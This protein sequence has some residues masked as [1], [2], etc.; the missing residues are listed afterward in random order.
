MCSQVLNGTRLKDP[1]FCNVYVECTNGEAIQNTCPENLYY[2]RQSA[3]CVDPATI[4]CLSSQPCL[5]KNWEF[6]S[7]PYSCNGYYYCTNGQAIYGECTKGS[8]FNPQAISCDTDYE[9]TISMYPESYCNVVPDGVAIKEGNSQPEA[10]EIC[11]DE[12]LYAGSCPQGYVFEPQQGDCSKDPTSAAQPTEPV[13]PKES[14]N[15]NELCPRLANGTLIKD[16]RACNEYFECAENGEVLPRSCGNLYFDRQT[17]ECVNP[18]K[19]ECLS[20]QPCKDKHG[21][22][23]ADPYSCQAYYYCD[24]G[25]A[26][27]AVCPNNVAFNPKKKVCDGKYKCELTMYP[28][29]YCNVVGEGV[30]IKDPQAENAYQICKNG[31]LLNVTCP[32]DFIF[33]AFRGKCVRDP[34]K[35]PETTTGVPEGTTKAP[36]TTVGTTQQS[37]EVPETTSKAPQTTK[38][39]VTTTRKPHSSSQAPETS[40]ST[41]QQ[42]TQEPETSTQGPE[43]TTKGPEITTQMPEITTKAPETSTQ[44]P[45]NTTKGP[46]TTTRTPQDPETTEEPETTDDPEG[47]EDPDV[48]EIPENPDDIFKPN[49]I[50][51]LVPNGTLIKDPRYCNTFVQCLNNSYDYGSCGEDLYF[52]RH[53]GN[54]TEPSATECLSTQPCL[55][56]S[57]VSVADPYSCQHYYKCK[58]NSVLYKKCSGNRNFNPATGKCEKKYDCQIVLYPEDICNIVGNGVSM[59]DPEVANGY[60]VCWDNELTKVLCSEG[61]IYDG[62]QGKCVKV[63]EVPETTAAP[64]TSMEPETSKEPEFTKPTK[65]TLGPETTQEVETTT[66]A[67]PTMAPET[68][69]MP[70]TTPE[71]EDPES[72]ESPN[73]SF[74]PNEWCSLLPNGTLIKDPRYCNTYVQCLDEGYISGTCGGD[75]YFDRHTGQCS[76][77][78]NTPCLSSK[79]CAGKNSGRAPDPYS[80]KGYYSCRYGIGVHRTCQ[81]GRNFNPQTLTCQWSYKCPSGGMVPEDT[82]NIVGEGVPIKDPNTDDG[83]QMCRD[84]KLE[85]VKCPENEIYDAYEGRCVGDSEVPQTTEAPGSSE[86]PGSTTTE[87]N[88]TTKE[89]ENTLEPETTTA[90]QTTASMEPE[91]TSGTDKPGSTLE[92][93]N[94]LEPETTTAHQTTAS[95]E[96]ETTSESDKPG[97]TLEPATTSGPENPGTST[98]EPETTTTEHQTTTEV[99]PTEVPEAPENPP[100]SFD[101]NEWCPML[102]NGTLIKDPRYCNTYVLCLNDSHS[103][104]TCGNLYFDRNT[105]KCSEPSRTDCLSSQPCLG[106]DGILVE[107][108]YSCKNYYSCQNGVGVHKTCFLFKNFNP[109]SQKCEWSYKCP[110]GMVPED[111]CNIVGE[112]VGIKVADMENGYQVCWGNKLETVM[113][114][115]YEIYDGFLGRCVRNGEVTEEPGITETTETTAGPETTKPNS[116]S[117]VPEATTK[118]PEVTESSQPTAGPET[119]LPTSS[120]QVPEVTT[121]EPEV[122]ESTQTTSGPETTTSEVPEVTTKEPEVTEPSQPTSGPETTKPTSTPELPETTTQ[123]PEVTESSQPTSGP[124]TTKPTSTPE[125]PETTTQEPEVPETTTTTRKPQPTRPT[126]PNAGSTTTSEPGTTMPTTTTDIPEFT[127]PTQKPENP[128]EPEP[129]IPDDPEDNFNPS[130]LCPLLA[131]GT[132][133]KDPNFCNIYVECMN[134]SWIEGSCGQLYFDA[135]TNSCVDPDSIKC[136]ST[137]PCLNKSGTFVADPYSC[138]N[139]YYCNNGVGTLGTCTS[140]MYFNPETGFCVRDFPCTIPLYPGDLCNIVPDG[141]NIQVPGSSQSYQTCWEAILYNNT[142]PDNFLYDAFKGYCVPTA[143]IE[144]PPDTEIP[145]DPEQYCPFIANGTLIKDPRYCNVYIECMNSTSITHSCPDDLEFNIQTLE[146]MEPSSAQCLTSQ[147]CRNKHAVSVADPYSCSN[148]FYC[149][150]GIATRAE[151]GPNENFNPQS[152]L[153]TPDFAC[154]IELYPQDICNIIPPGVGISS[155]S[156]DESLYQICNDKKLENHFCADNWHFDAFSGE[157]VRPEIKCTTD[158]IFISDGYS[159]DGYYYCMASGDGFQMIYGKCQTNRFFDPSD[160]GKC[161]L[162]TNIACPYNRCVT[163]GFEEIQMANINGDGCRGFS[164]CQD[165]EEIGRNTCPA[166]MYFDEA[167]QR[168]EDHEVTYEACK[169]RK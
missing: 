30:K 34:A 114:P 16:P 163:L 68:T 65:P 107:D 55:N 149:Y 115:E 116:T 104:G 9:C 166:E 118:E 18:N 23:V 130:A 84:N 11:W 96:P 142:C 49:E 101:P 155:S 48:P 136:I 82:C 56:K 29:D 89:P 25:N 21:E 6:V 31:V 120:P 20:S 93:E 92:P 105:G 43:T 111:T 15:P 59:V 17:G 46:E 80:C 160:G 24:R 106:R 69:N 94:T 119:T 147:P 39:P 121:K 158:G 125:L 58:K 162:R 138:Q 128:E 102:P 42:P 37:T 167:T 71:T 100:T 5:N 53:G 61:M 112:G 22:F 41:S 7:D 152:G 32:E 161:A 27:K 50:C 52:N 76:S 83:Y 85:Y 12:E 74:D 35:E 140:G 127:E 103:S 63:T 157:C 45:E 79:P 51:P 70:T 10:F 122:T 98:L 28:E 57:E 153:C 165:G 1:R 144:N 33:D 145:F 168:C 19:V 137:Q 117:E 132:R 95:M 159:C 141:V 86:R 113:C 77:P 67:K 14:F 150:E 38:E 110:G 64:E 151:C 135:E 13:E 47:P 4:K 72:P 169:A 143:A 124:E 78:S 134:N 131:N 81:L 146:C 97:S 26:I 36:E 133:I 8:T 109:S 139:Y 73:G 123:E 44:G 87:P 60:Q 126:P 88:H 91:T 164:L 3:S 90:S 156:T 66:E 99:Q 62:F 40:T 154:G 129:E 75:L 2:D 54:C 148:Y 108:P